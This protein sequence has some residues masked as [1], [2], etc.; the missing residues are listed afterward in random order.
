MSAAEIP[1]QLLAALGSEQQCDQGPGARADHQKCDRCS[2]A[3]LVGGFVFSNLHKGHLSWSIRVLRGMYIL[4]H[5]SL[6]AP[7]PS[8]ISLRAKALVCF[9]PCF[10]RIPQ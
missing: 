4:G 9:A 1:A 8:R 3:A 10:G 2:D 6:P 5:S 7:V